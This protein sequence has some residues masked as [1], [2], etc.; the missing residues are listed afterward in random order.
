VNLLDAVVEGPV[1]VGVVL[2]LDLGVGG[3][4]GGLRGE[5]GEVL[6][7]REYLVPCRRRRP[8]RRRTEDLPFSLD[9][10]IA[11][12]SG[13]D[14]RGGEEFVVDLVRWGGRHP[15]GMLGGIC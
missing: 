2:D 13:G 11:G 10:G 1:G 7:R 6:A 3:G 4:S 12:L 9:R 5:P 8:R 14:G 15:A